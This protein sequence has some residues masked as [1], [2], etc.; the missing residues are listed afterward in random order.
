M[1]RFKKETETKE[2]IEFPKPLKLE[3]E[4][5]DDYYSLL[6]QTEASKT[7]ILNCYLHKEEFIIYNNEEVTK[8]LKSIC[9]KDKNVCW[10]NYSG[11]EKPVPIEAIKIINTIKTEL[12]YVQF[13]IS[14]FD[15]PKLDPFLVARVSKTNWF[16][17]LD[18]T[19]FIIFRWDEPGFKIG[20][21]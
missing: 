13:Y 5:D 6:K 21:Q 18:N 17:S 1:S 16:Y 8:Y 4:V 19:S 7:Q 3:Q 11:Y 14:D 9:P 2:V 12:P 10:T 20:K 15:M